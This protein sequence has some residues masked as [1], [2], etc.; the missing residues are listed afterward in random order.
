MSN[1]VPSHIL[2]C[3]EHYKEIENYELAK[4]DNFEGWV[5]HHRNGEEFSTLWLKKNNMYYNRLDPHEFKFVTKKEHRKIHAKVY[6]SY[7]FKG[8]K[9]S[10]ETLCKIK[11]SAIGHHRNKGIPSERKDRG[12]SEFGI[13]FVNT[14]G[15]GRVT[16]P[17]EYERER[18]YYKVHGHLKKE[19][20]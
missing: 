7:G 1:Y 8:K 19:G 11:E 10:K 18:K 12:Y 16:F 15:A 3:P 2:F 14:Y 4:A 9:H 13:L 20:Q 5:C 6:A 17:K